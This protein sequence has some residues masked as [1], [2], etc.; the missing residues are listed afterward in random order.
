MIRTLKAMYRTGG[1]EDALS[2]L[3]A[4]PGIGILYAIVFALS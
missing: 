2:V 3:L 4:F 1:L